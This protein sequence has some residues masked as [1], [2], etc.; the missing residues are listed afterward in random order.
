MNEGK[1]NTTATGPGRLLVKSA[2]GAI[3]FAFQA[4][5]VHAAQAAPLSA[6]PRYF[7]SF[8]VDGLLGLE[9]FSWAA[10][11]ISAAFAVVA[12]IGCIA[13]GWDGEAA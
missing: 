12:L 2:L 8:M 7:P 11:V 4:S 6:F 9:Y 3:G 10:A 13:V 5:V 1:T